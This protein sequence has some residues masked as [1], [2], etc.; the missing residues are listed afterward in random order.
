M[1]LIYSCLVANE[2][3]D[4]TIFDFKDAKL[5]KN[6]VIYKFFILRRYQRNRSVIRRD[7]VATGNFLSLMRNV[8][9]FD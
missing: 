1:I 7:G 3:C 4:K 8:D 5:Q 6:L 9:G 2:M